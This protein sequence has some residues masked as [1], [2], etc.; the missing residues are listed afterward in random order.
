MVMQPYE[1]LNLERKNFSQ[2]QVLRFRE[3]FFSHNR[4]VQFREKFFIFQSLANSVVASPY[5]NGFKL[6][7]RLNCKLLYYSKI[8]ENAVH[9]HGK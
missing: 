7:L 5:S 1:Q 6:R 9:A 3:K 2:N 4:N 8:Q